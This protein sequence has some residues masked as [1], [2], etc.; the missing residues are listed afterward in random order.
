MKRILS[1]FLVI[2][3]L[4]VTV[5]AEHVHV[6]QVS[7][8]V[9]NPIADQLLTESVTLDTSVFEGAPDYILKD[10]SQTFQMLGD[11]DSHQV[12]MLTDVAVVYQVRKI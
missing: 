4:H 7:K 1:I 3:M 2:S 10:D 8:E 6:N 9:T 5:F 11:L 12:G